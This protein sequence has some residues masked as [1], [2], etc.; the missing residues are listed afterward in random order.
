[1]GAAGLV[2]LAVAACGGGASHEG[3]PALAAQV[4]LSPTPPMVGE[5]VVRVVATDDGAPLAPEARVTV[6]VGDAGSP[7]ELRPEAGAWVGSMTF[8]DPGEARVVVE[9]E[10]ADGRRATV[11]VPV[12]VSRSP[13]PGS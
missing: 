9:I 2:L 11:T 7:V 5:A 8:S 6:T 13:L 1:M 3:D 12:Q 4:Q 10:A